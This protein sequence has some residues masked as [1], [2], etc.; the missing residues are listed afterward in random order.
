MR[1]ATSKE[2]HERFASCSDF[3][4]ALGGQKVGDTK[5]QGGRSVWFAVAAVALLAVL[6]AG[7]YG[8]LHKVVFNGN[9]AL[10]GGVILEMVK[11]PAG[12]FLRDDGKMVRLTKSYWLGKYEVTNE[13]WRAVMSGRRA[14]QDGTVLSDPS[15]WKES[16]RPVEG[17]SWNDAMDFCKRLNE[18]YADQLPRGYRIDLPTEA[19]W[20]YACRAGTTTN[21]SYGN[22]SDTDKMNFEGNYPYGG[23]SKGVYRAATV[24]VGSL[25]Y[26]NAFGLY[27]MHGNVWEW[28]RD[29]YETYGSDTTDPTGPATG[30]KRVARG[31]SWN[32]Y[33]SDCRSVR[34][35]N[36]DPGCRLIILGF[37]PAL[38]PVQWWDGS[39]SIDF[40]SIQV[41]WEKSGWFNDIKFEDFKQFFIA[42]Q[43]KYE[44]ENGSELKRLA[45]EH[46]K[47]IILLYLGSAIKLTDNPEN[48]K[49]SFIQGWIHPEDG[50][51]IRME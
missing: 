33:S 19:Q 36:F 23:G 42:E 48:Y 20:E 24:D 49:K 16:K 51:K 32:D 35:F 26:K 1:H 12:E 39:H 22:A 45:R 46:A 11:I 8:S 50:Y 28:C 14:S 6:V 41:F 2:P 27:D 21:Y 40:E 4:A 38:V 43:K 29:W 31:G 10:P 44:E 13:Q 15:K 5:R 25:G 30:S 34:R 7:W 18:L 47:K 3:A 9:V 17:V 37:R